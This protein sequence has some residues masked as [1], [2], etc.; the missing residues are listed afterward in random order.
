MFKTIGSGPLAPDA[1]DG[2]EGAGPREPDAVD[3]TGGTRGASPAEVELAPAHLL[4]EPTPREEAAMASSTRG[5]KLL[6]SSFK[7]G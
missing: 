4:F 3:V 5:F 1:V 7:F 6:G 2:T